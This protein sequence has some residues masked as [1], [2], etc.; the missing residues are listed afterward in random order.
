[1]P[2]QT[3]LLPSPTR[4]LSQYCPY[5]P[6]CL[7]P[8]LTSPDLHPHTLWSPGFS[9]SPPEVSKP[10]F[11]STTTP[12]SSAQTMAATSWEPS[13]TSGPG[14]ND[15]CL[16]TS[17][18]VCWVGRGLCFCSMVAICSLKVAP[19][20]TGQWATGR[21]RDVTAAGPGLGTSQAPQLAVRFLCATGSI[22]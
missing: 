20:L 4:Y 11:L 2:P 19:S 7:E 10:L 1:M 15:M 18:R 17:S 3:F 9:L 5:F 22:S 13:H 6:S 16:Q 8:P 12:V 21:V 14:E